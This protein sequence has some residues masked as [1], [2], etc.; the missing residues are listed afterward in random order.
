MD[1]FRDREPDELRR[2]NAVRQIVGF[3]RERSINQA[4][5]N[6]LQI[7]ED[8]D[9][10]EDEILATDV[11]EFTRQAALVDYMLRSSPE[12]AAE[13]STRLLGAFLEDGHDVSA[14]LAFIDMMGRWPRADD[15]ELA[16]LCAAEIFRA[17]GY[18]EIYIPERD[19]LEAKRQMALQPGLV[20]EK[21]MVAIWM[22]RLLL[23]ARA[24]DGSKLPVQI[25]KVTSHVAHLDLIPEL[26]DRAEPVHAVRAREAMREMRLIIL[27]NYLLGINYDL[28]HGLYRP[29]GLLDDRDAM[30]DALPPHIFDRLPIA[31]DPRD[32]LLKLAQIADEMAG[33]GISTGELVNRSRTAYF[34]RILNYA[35]HLYLLGVMRQGKD[36]GNLFTPA[37]T[38][39]YAHLVLP[40]SEETDS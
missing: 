29:N 39:Y 35:N 16:L 32:E 7:S 15:A 31:G 30:R 19:S 22:K 5:I 36:G 23:E 25:D 3:E 2:L 10:N 27:A 18:D 17:N 8:G 14:T 40:P 13:D 37:T 12:Q 9:V 21:G 4:A 34:N 28:M 38:R 20:Q 1:R 6:T 33:Y 11:E 26:A 24:S